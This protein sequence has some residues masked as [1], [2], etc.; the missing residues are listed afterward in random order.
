[1]RNIQSKGIFFLF[2]LGLS[3]FSDNLFKTPRNPGLPNS[4]MFESGEEGG[5]ASRIEFDWLRLKSPH[6]NTIPTGIKR[7]ALEFSKN[8]PIRRGI[9]D[10]LKRS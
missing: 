4:L 6:T 5:P 2:L 8:I 10:G 7:R 3:F 1:M 9:K